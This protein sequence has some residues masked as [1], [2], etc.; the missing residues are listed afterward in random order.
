MGAAQASKSQ[1]YHY[2]GDKHGLVQAVVDHQSAEVLGFQ[3]RLLAGVRSWEGLERWADETVAVF[4]RQGCRGGC[5]LG[6]M[7]AA[8][9]D[10]D[11]RLLEQL[12]DA[13]AT[14][15]DAIMGALIRLRDGGLLPP[16][17]NLEKLT[18]TMLAAIQGGLLL[19]KTTRDSGQLRTALDGAIAHLRA[20]ASNHPSN[21]RRPPS[22]NQPR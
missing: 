20:H 17:A 10:T 9:A 21:R 18:T 13:F 14:W 3:A 16:N 2:F 5:P 1:L 19:G 7:A 22:G 6:T 12:S 15:R 4:E 11:E 8:V